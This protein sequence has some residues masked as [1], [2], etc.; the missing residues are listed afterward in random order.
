[1]VVQKIDLGFEMTIGIIAKLTCKDGMNAA[2]EA[3]FKK[4]Q[5]VVKKNEPGCIF[6][7]LHKSR[8]E[9]TVYYVMEQYSDTEA[10]EHHGSYEAFRETSK[11]LG[12]LSGGK[13]EVTVMDEV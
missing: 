12:P 13:P 7:L 6:Y 3:G 4:L 9:G 11:A 2:F 10:L 1:M 5:A 8:E